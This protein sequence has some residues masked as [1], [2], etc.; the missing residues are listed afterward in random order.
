MPLGPD[1]SHCMLVGKIAGIEDRG[2][3]DRLVTLVIKERWEYGD[4][5]LGEKE[6]RPTIFVPFSVIKNKASLQHGMWMD[7]FGSLRI[8]SEGKIEIMASRV[9]TWR[10]KDE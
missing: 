10:I 8:T 9:R 3:G 5:D 7:V 6:L 4:V 2:N 1:M